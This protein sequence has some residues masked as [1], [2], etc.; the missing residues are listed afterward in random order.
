MGVLETKKV[1]QP[2]K[3]RRMTKTRRQLQLILKVT[4]IVALVLALGSLVYIA[5]F[6]KYETIDLGELTKAEINGYNGHGTVS[7]TTE[8]VT[9]YENFFETVHVN[10]VDSEEAV[11]GMLSNGDKV[12][13]EY[14]YDK[15]VAKASGLKVKAKTEYINI[16]DL[17]DAKVVSCDELFA[18][19]DFSYEGIAPLVTI[20]MNNNTTNEVLKTV[21]FQIRNEKEYYDVGDTVIV[22]AVF[23]E[24]VMAANTYE[25]T[26]GANGYSKEF[27][28]SGCDRYLTDYTELPADILQQMKEHG[29]TLFGQNSGDANEFGLRVFSDAGLMYTTENTKYTFRFTGTRY[30]SSYFAN[31]EP[32]HIGEVGTHVNDVKIVYDTGVS[33]SDGQSVTAEAVVIYRNIIKKADGTIEVNLDEGEIISVSRR[34]AQIKEL[35]RGTEDDQ[36]SS[37]K[38]EQ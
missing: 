9:G 19:I 10:I 3:R 12:E 21:E 2:P 5:G 6:A 31:V 38:L 27:T 23:D 34:D 14:T 17:P 11:N 28:I 8:I 35:V 1:I 30:I 36:Y 26:P 13:I 33:Q 25:I 22:D 37:V 18:G 15:K 4:V 7:T 32:E 20:T 29:A 24:A 16:K